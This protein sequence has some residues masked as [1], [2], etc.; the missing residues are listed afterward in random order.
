MCAQCVQTV[1]H[2]FISPDGLAP[3]SLPPHSFA[4]YV[5]P[6]MSIFRVD[7]SSVA[8]P[9]LQRVQLFLAGTGA[10]LISLLRRLLFD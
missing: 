5:V 2:L 4:W 6:I 3:S 1:K 8:E 10:D 9:E 7:N